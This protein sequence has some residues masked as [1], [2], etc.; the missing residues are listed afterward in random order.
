MQDAS[1]L[2]AD[3]IVDIESQKNLEIQN[4]HFQINQENSSRLA[5]NGG[6]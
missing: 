2:I 3:H 6:K 4:S 1:I 5:N